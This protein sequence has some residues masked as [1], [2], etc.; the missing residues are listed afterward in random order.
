L[1]DTYETQEEEIYMRD[2]RDNDALTKLSFLFVFAT[3]NIHYMYIYFTS[4]TK[5]DMSMYT[6]A[7]KLFP[8]NN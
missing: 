7:Q 3:F 1:F 5:T 2:N 6:H 8:L 4:I